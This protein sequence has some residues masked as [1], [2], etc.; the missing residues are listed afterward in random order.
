MVPQFDRPIGAAAEKDIGHTGRPPH[1][2]HRALH[3]GRGKQLDLGETSAKE[4]NTNYVTTKNN[5]YETK[6]NKKCRSL[7]F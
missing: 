4:N 3:M 2:V 1:P 6:V 7:H 5:C